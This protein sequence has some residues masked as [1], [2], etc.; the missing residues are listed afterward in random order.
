MRFTEIVFL[1]EEDVDAAHDAA[2]RRGGGPQGIISRGLIISATMAPQ[3]GYYGSLAEIAAVYA[4]GIAKNHGYRDGNKRTAVVA[5][6]Q[7]LGVNGYD[8]EL[9]PEWPA[10]IEAVVKG[11]MTR[12]QLAAR[13]AMLMGGDPVTIEQE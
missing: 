3:N 6:A 5:F 2:L 13:I 8:V 9:G 1:K 10:V 7:F 4:H 11:D 12:D